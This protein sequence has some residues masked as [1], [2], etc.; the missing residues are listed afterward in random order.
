[1][2]TLSKICISS[3]QNLKTEML[4][5]FCD[6][7]YLFRYVHQWMAPGVTG[8]RGVPVPRTAFTCDAAAVRPRLRPTGAAT[9]RARTSRARTARAAC[10]GPSWRPPVTTCP[11]WSTRSRM[12]PRPRFQG[13]VVVGPGFRPLI[14]RSTSDWPS[15][16]WSLC[17]SWSLSSGCSKGNGQLTLDTLLQVQIIQFYLTF[18][19]F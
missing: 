16:S 15:P 12:R 18:R 10:A 8:P 19:I 9:A 1:M 2:Y 5:F 7:K 6:S 4:D 3:F 17:S 13:V 11:S 14:S